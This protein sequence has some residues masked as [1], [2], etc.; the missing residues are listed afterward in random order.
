MFTRF[1][2]PAFIKPLRATLDAE[3]L[4]FLE[5]KKAF[6]LPPAA[7]QREFMR[8][9]IHYVHPF[10]PLLD[11]D[12]ILVPL[13]DSPGSTQ[14]SLVL[15]QA[16]MFAAASFV[17]M[18]SLQKE[19]FSSQLDARR[20]L[21][22]RVKASYSA[23]PPNE[24]VLISILKLLV[25]FDVENDL[26]TLT[27]VL[28]LMTNWYDKPDDP[29]GPSYWMNIAL[30]FAYEIGL[31][32]DSEAVRLDAKQQRTRRRLWWCCYCRDKVISFSERRP[33]GIRGGENHLAVLTPD[34]FEPQLFSQALRGYPAPGIV[35]RP[36]ILIELSIEHMKLCV[37]L[38]RV[39]DTQYLAS[40]HRRT[41]TG[42]M[43]MILR[44]QSSE[45]FMSDFMISDQELSEWGEAICS[46]LRG[47]IDVEPE[48]NCR[49]VG[50]HS[51]VLEMVYH[52][53]LSMLHL[54][55]MALKHPTISAAQALHDSSRQKLR[56]GAR[57]ITEIARYLGD[58]NLLNHVPPI[59]VTALV[60][61][62]VQHV[63]DTISSDTEGHDSAVESFR[64]TM[65]ALSQL[66]EVYASAGHAISCIETV[67]ERIT[68][69]IANES[70]TE[71]RKIPYPHGRMNYSTQVH[72]ARRTTDSHVDMASGR[73]APLDGG[74]GLTPLSP[75]PIFAGLETPRAD[76]LGFETVSNLDGL[77]EILL[78][79]NFRVSDFDGMDWTSIF[80]DPDF[81]RF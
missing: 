24:Y 16:V 53:A 46:R 61:A 32:R 77:S 34:D 68:H 19:G 55:L 41:A 1:D 18:E 30:S 27:K 63:K 6:S 13:N 67:R 65:H 38:G 71:Q 58:H 69:N 74:F 14:I 59:G 78:S 42:E 50:L 60:A 52:T 5:L 79:E 76:P 70:N 12:D 75:A 21:F 49:L 15:Y 72:Q 81:M 9:Y 73:I 10:L 39:L 35:T 36:E 51:A 7:V 23:A 40:G 11:L 48:H 31:D 28:V 3:S 54:P 47:A 17:S 62:A 26:L 66:R 57:R 44:P 64:Q 80:Q 56:D 8:G 20:C 25:D 37:L 22:Q 2:F 29:K 45:T 4:V 43:M 33:S